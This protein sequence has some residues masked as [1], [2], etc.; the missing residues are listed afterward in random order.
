MG[1]NLLQVLAKLWTL[2]QNPVFGPIVIAVVG[3]LVKGDINGLVTYLESLLQP[4]APVNVIPDSNQLRPI[5]DEL[6]QAHKVAL[7]PVKP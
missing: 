4:N 5:I 1:A 7:N 2:L 6:K 3:Y